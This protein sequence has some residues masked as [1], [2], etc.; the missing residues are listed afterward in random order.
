M[1]ELKTTREILG[2][3]S[4][5]A[6]LTQHAGAWFPK[7]C[8]ALLLEGAAGPEV[9]LADNL[10]DKYHA[11]DPATYPRSGE[12]AYVLDPRLIA[13]AESDGKR[14]VAIVHS[15]CNVG[16]YFSDEDVRQA[17]SPFEDGPLYPGV[18]YVVL[19]A[20]PDGVKGFKVFAWS[21]AGERFV[22]V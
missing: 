5:V 14:L 11:L 22:E 2:A 17:T 21:E 7:E 6:A 3:Q 16:A 15:H 13:K 10:A 1:A 8:C 9:I 4:I 12:R 19:D 18:D 20:Q